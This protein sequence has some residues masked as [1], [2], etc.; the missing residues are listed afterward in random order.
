MQYSQLHN[1]DF[2]R[3]SDLLT[4]F[5]EY[6][7]GKTDVLGQIRIINYANGKYVLLKDEKQLNGFVLDLKN[8]SDENFMLDN[9]LQIIVKLFS[10]YIKKD[11]NYPLSNNEFHMQNTN[12]Y[13]INPFGFSTSDY[14]KIFVSTLPDEMR[15]I[16]RNTKLFLNVGDGRGQINYSN[17]NKSNYRLVIDSFHEIIKRISAES[18]TNNND[19]EFE[20]EFQMKESFNHNIG[21][22]DLSYVAKNLT[23]P[24][25]NFINN[26]NLGPVRILGPAGTGKTVSLLLKSLYVA[27]LYENKGTDIS[28]CFVCHSEAMKDSIVTRLELE[29]DGSRYLNNTT[30]VM[31]KVY[32]LLDWCIEFAVT[33]FNKT[34]CLEVDSADSKLMQEML[35]DSA[36]KKFKEEDFSTFRPLLSR[37]FLEF[38]EQTNIGKLVKLFQSEISIFIKGSNIQTVGD[39]RKNAKK[40]KLLPW[41]NENDLGLVYSIY[42]KYQQALLDM[43]KYDLDDVT[44]VA[45]SYLKQGI[46]KRERKNLGFDVLFVDELHLFDF[47]ELNIMRCMLKNELDNHII[48]ATDVAQSIGDVDIIQSNINSIIAGDILTDKSLNLIFRSSEKIIDLVNF[49]FN[50]QMH[51]FANINPM[52]NAKI[53][54]TNIN[55]Q[56]PELVEVLN[57]EMLIAEVFKGKQFQTNEKSKILNVLTDLNLLDKFKEYMAKENIPFIIINKRN[58]L[59]SVL[60]AQKESKLL[61]GYIDYIG[62]LEF[63]YV[64]IIGFDKNRVPPEDNALSKDFFEHIWYRKVY[65]AFTRARYM[66]KIYSNIE[67]GKHSFLEKALEKKYLSKT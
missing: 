51:L 41:E 12:F 55:N 11:K 6:E 10:F 22:F 21:S 36:I 53:I 46:W 39:Y 52:S 48:Y 28:I 64:H 13:F 4:Y 26:D 16:K 34:S 9:I 49:L 30:G 35:I 31:I 1:A 67:N 7:D 27:K 60:K 25:K 3:G 63:D 56:Q 8:S 32:S 42:E 37:G 29:Q 47:H 20:Y 33:N 18:I 58:E 19:K 17:Y 40:D 61:F 45:L 24:Q 15:D 57:D 66:L 54:E 38:F 5:R 14:Y 65:V 23:I 59:T 43:N 62:G 44:N 50:S 2:E